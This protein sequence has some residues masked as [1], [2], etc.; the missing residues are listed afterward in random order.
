MD[1]QSFE[2]AENAMR[3]QDYQA[4]ERAFSRL[5][6]DAADHNEHNNLLSSY[7]GLAQVLTGNDNGL[8]LCRDAAGSET[9]AG[10]VYLNLACAE[11]HAG[12]RRRAIDAIQRGIKIDEHNQQLKAACAKLDC[13]KKCCF[14]FLPRGHCLNRRLG[15]LFRRSAQV[16]GVHDLLFPV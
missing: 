4:A 16:P 8:L 6:N 15:R 7:L 1:S 11:W 13:R 3:S 10:Q 14:G 12:N 9:L 5:V 2:Q